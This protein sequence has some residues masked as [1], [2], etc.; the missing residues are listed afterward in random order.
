MPS[1][2]LVFFGECG[3]ALFSV[4]GSASSATVEREVVP[5]FGSFPGCLAAVV[6]HFMPGSQLFLSLSLPSL[7]LLR[8]GRIVSDGTGGRPKSAWFA[9]LK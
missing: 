6:P 7:G 4:V 1:E 2:A 3:F 8:E 9:G 5:V